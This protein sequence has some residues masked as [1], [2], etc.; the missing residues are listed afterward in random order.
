[1]SEVRYR[2]DVVEFVIGTPDRPP[3]A[4]LCGCWAIDEGDGIYRLVACDEH[5]P[6]FDETVE[7]AD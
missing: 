7:S 6:E 4:W 5:R 2:R 1:M 3:L